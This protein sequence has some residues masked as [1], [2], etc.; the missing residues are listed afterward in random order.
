MEKVNYYSPEDEC[1]VDLFNKWKK[2]CILFD[3]KLMV[4]D[5][6]KLVQVPK[7]NWCFWKKGTEEVFT[8]VEAI[9]FLTYDKDGNSKR[10][11]TTE[12]FLYTG[13]NEKFFVDARQKWEAHKKFLSSLGFVIEKQS[14]P[15]DI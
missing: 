10:Q 3:G 1:L 2:Q 14:K 5:E 12:Y 11:S 15:L 6:I 8:K 9:Y 4:M 7:R 13:L